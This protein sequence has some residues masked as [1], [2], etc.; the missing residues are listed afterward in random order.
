MELK[1]T[2][3]LALLLNQLNSA[4]DENGNDLLNAIQ[5]KYNFN[6]LQKL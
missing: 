1:P 6:E 5:S 4:I 3:D 2:P